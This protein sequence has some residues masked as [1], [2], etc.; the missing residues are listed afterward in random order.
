MCAS[1]NE[2][3]FTILFLAAAFALCCALAMFN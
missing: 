2:S 1:P 3:T